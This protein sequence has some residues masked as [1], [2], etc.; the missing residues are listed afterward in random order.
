MRKIQIDEEVWEALTKRA[1]P[2]EDTPNSVLR[3]LLGLDKKPIRKGKVLVGHMP[4]PEYRR[5]I[6]E[7]LEEMGGRGKVDEVLRRVFEKVKTKLKDVD[8]EALPSAKE[9]RWRNS[10]RWQ[11]QYM[12]NDGLLRND[13]PR[14][15]WEITEKGRQYLRRQH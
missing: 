13:S 1:K 14:G 5:P 6:L 7:A 15:V 9:L 11:R 12:V 3:R 8:R 10:A 2:L 4:H